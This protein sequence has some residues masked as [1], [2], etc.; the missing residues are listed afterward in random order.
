M[1][2]NK[3]VYIKLEQLLNIY[4]LILAFLPRCFRYHATLTT[5]I[6]LRFLRLARDLALSLFRSS[7]PVGW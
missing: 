6:I 7:V 5:R 3:M 2:I 1:N 4:T